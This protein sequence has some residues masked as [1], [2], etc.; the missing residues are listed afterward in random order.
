[1]SDCSIRKVY[2]VDKD[3]TL[4]AICIDLQQT[5]PTPRISTSVQYYKPK[6]WTYNFCIHS[7]KDKQS[8]MYV[9]NESV[10][11]RGS[12]G[13]GSCSMYYVNNVLGD[14]IT[15]LII[16]SD[17]CSGQNKNI[18]L[19]LLLLRL[20]QSERFNAI[21]QYFLYSRT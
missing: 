1:M 10:A 14:D 5:L 20:V 2:A 18:N 16:F 13:I 6:M 11:K 19:S 21:Q 8:Y 4:A 3:A 12:T 17:N 9:W 15:Q 7:L